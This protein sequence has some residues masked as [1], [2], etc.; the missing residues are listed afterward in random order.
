[1]DAFAFADDL[2]AMVL[3]ADFSEN[4]A[5]QLADYHQ[6]LHYWGVQNRVVFDPLKE[7]TRI[8]CRHKPSG[9]DFKLLGVT[10]DCKL[11]IKKAVDSAAAQCETACFTSC[12]TVFATS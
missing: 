2:N 11:I 8:L 7:S 10:F 6:G 9:D 5:N 3:S 1:M 12:G 4:I